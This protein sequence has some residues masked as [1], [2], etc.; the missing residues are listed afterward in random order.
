MNF[1]SKMGGVKGMNMTNF[2]F[3]AFYLSNRE[4]KKVGIY[5]SRRTLILFH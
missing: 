2:L 1:N 5:A 4:S 3:L